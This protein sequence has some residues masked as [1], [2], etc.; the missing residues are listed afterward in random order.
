MMMVIVSEMG[1]KQVGMIHLLQ[2]WVGMMDL[3]L[4]LVLVEVVEAMV[5]WEEDLEAHKWGSME[6][7]WAMEDQ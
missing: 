4:S 7:T 2:R 3:G 5:P 1:S 6:V